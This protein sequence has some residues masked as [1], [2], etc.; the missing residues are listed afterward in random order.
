MWTAGY[1]DGDHM[2]KTATIGLDAFA[3]AGCCVAGIFGMGVAPIPI[4]SLVLGFVGMAFFVKRAERA[5][6]A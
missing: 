1:A 6:A 5:R 4:A 2:R 3:A